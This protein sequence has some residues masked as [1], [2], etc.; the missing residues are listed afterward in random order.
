M[1]MMIIKKNLLYLCSLIVISLT[2]TLTFASAKRDIPPCPA[3]TRRIF[4]PS[5]AKPLWAACKDQ[6][7]FYQ[8][9]LIQ[10][11]NQ[12]EI[13]RIAAVKNSFRHGK[14]IRAGSAETTEERHY[15]NGHLE[16]GSFI[17]KTETNL[18]RLMPKPTTEKDWLSFN[19]VS[20]TSLLKEWIKKEPEITLEFNNGR[21]VRQKYEKVNYTFKISGDGRI[22][23][24]NH[25][26]L[27]E[28]K[29]LFFTDTEPLW[30][31]NAADLKKALLPGFGTCKK[32]AGPIGRY[33]RRYEHYLFKREPSESK[34]LAQLNTIRDRF[35]KFCIPT[36][37]IEHLGVLECPPLLPSTR[38]PKYCAIAISDQMHLPYEPKYFKNEFTMGLMPEDF[39]AV[40]NKNGLLKFASDYE[41]TWDVIKIPGGTQLIVKKTARGIFYKL[42]KKDKSGKFKIE[43]P[44]SND[45]AWWEWT[46]V[47]GFSTY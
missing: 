33:T 32:Y 2:P 46:A 16:K 5:E 43:E 6:R 29:S 38:P 19:K 21:L 34:Q 4:I 36:D 23:P 45:K 17:F 31:L 9:L 30:F 41:K 24:T 47:P 44:S 18:D 42:V 13:I 27:K 20:E 22:F 10:F 15:L 40:L 25:P 26:D 14:E 7:G 1:K 12:T 35:V 39:S 11:S 37:I 3:N 8:G 28:T